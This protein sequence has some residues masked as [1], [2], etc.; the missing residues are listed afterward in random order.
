MP[1]ISE[2]DKLNFKSLFDFSHLQ[3]I[4]SFNFGA[5]GVQ[6]RTK[7]NHPDWVDMQNEVQRDIEAQNSL[8]DAS[9]LPNSG[10]ILK[11]M[12]DDMKKISTAIKKAVVAQYATNLETMFK[13]NKRFQSSLGKLLKLL[14]S[15]HLQPKKERARLEKQKAPSAEEQGL[16]SKKSKEPKVEKISRNNKRSLLKSYYEK[17]EKY[18][19]INKQDAVERLNDK[20]KRLKELHVTRKVNNGYMKIK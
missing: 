17:I 8:S 20:I 1:T 19:R 16:S 6:E 13:D 7:E 11:D 9:E 12:I 10:K 14:L 15:L 3:A 18:S 5:T 4:N 2:E